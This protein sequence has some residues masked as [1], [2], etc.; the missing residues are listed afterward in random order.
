MNR[1]ALHEILR[2][3]GYD[4]DKSDEYLRNYRHAISHLRDLPIALMEIGVNRGGSLFL[5]RDYFTRGNIVGV[6]LNPPE[7]FADSSGRIHL[8]RGDQG[9]VAQMDTIAGQAS[10]DGFHIII[11]DAS[12][13]GSLTAIAFQTLFYKH[14]KPGGFYAIED[15]GTGY[16]KSWP[17]GAEPVHHDKVRFDSHENQFSS[18][19][20]GMVGF[21][22]QLI[23]EAALADI[24]HLKWG[25]PGNRQSH[26]RS[27]HV[28]NGLA[29][30]EKGLN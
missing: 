14:L 23:D 9:D 26:I 17:D 24:L 28:S 4:T 8:F 22:K 16:W 29:I 3:K 27:I 15:W 20:H 12:H 11:D 2:Q 6:D 19:Q 5:W 25:V 13:L 18:H 7:D 21:L 30:I 1:P 10:P